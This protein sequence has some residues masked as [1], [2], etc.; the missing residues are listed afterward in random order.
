M[1]TTLVLV[2]LSATATALSLGSSRVQR[3]P[4]AASARSRAP[5]PVAQQQRYDDAIFDESKPD[6]VFDADI[7]YR[8]R[9]SFGF[10]SAA[11][12]LN[13]RA[14]MMGFT[15]CFLQEL[16]FGKGVLEQYGLPYDPGAFLG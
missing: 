1:R 4:S 16:I 5:T 8:G 14:A 15:I 9:S 3:A 2:C 10:V 12:R 13:G 6:P 11:E 7:G